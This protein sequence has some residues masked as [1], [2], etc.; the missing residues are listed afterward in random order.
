ML[1]LL[2]CP[3]GIPILAVIKPDMPGGIACEKRYTLT[4]P[5]ALCRTHLPVSVALGHRAT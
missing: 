1:H 4:V 2:M 5:G 3:L